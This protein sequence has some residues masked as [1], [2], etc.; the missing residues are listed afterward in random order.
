MQVDC[1]HFCYRLY[2]FV[3]VDWNFDDILQRFIKYNKLKVSPRENVWSIGF[4]PT[5]L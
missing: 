5:D 1:N 3:S 2:F 4:T